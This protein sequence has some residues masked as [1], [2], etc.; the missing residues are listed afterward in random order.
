MG[1][2][3]RV[4]VRGFV[5]RISVLGA[6]GRYTAKYTCFRHGLSA[7]CKVVAVLMTAPM[8]EGP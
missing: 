1:R 8:Q 6:L 4:L 2:E 5:A 3:F 7:D